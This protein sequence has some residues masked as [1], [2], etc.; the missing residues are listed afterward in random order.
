MIKALRK[1]NDVKNKQSIYR[2]KP[3]GLK[4]STKNNYNDTSKNINKQTNK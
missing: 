3:T 1:F 4:E 2:V